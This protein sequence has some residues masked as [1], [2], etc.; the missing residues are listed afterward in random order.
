MRKSVVVLG[1]I[2]AAAIVIGC[3]KKPREEASLMQEIAY[4]NE[5]IMN[6]E[7]NAA[8][9][10]TITDTTAALTD[11]TQTDTTSMASLSV[12]SNPTGRD[13][14]QALKNAGVYEGKIDG[15]IGPKSKK[16]IR[17]FQAQND[18]K[19]DGKVGPKTWARLGQYLSQT[20]T[21][22]TTTD[23]SAAGAASQQTIVGE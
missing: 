10:Q 13:I 17:D 8:L 15:S 23:L 2:V 19:V 4:E 21:A 14:Q 6:T 9:P 7:T 11:A 5:M 16:A 22:S 20:Q 1:V 12:P 18:L 3:N